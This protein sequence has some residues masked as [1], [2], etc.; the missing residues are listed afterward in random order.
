MG[1]PMKE[2][3]KSDKTSEPVFSITVD[4]MKHIIN[5]VVNKQYF[6]EPP[7]LRWVCMNIQEQE[8]FIKWFCSTHTNY[9]M[10]F[11]FSLFAEGCDT[12]DQILGNGLRHW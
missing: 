1:N 4:D 6:G 11:Y 8:H 2:I 7:Y 10:C 9:D 3:K 12:S 5:E